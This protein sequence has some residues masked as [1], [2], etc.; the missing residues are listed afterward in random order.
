MK[1]NQIQDVKNNRRLILSLFRSN[2]A[3]NK[4]CSE[5]EPKSIDDTE[6]DLLRSNDNFKAGLPNRTKLNFGLYLLLTF[7][8]KKLLQSVED[9]KNKGINRLSFSFSDVVTNLPQLESTPSIGH[10]CF[11]N[12]LTIVVQELKGLSIDFEIDGDE[13]F[14]T[15]VE[16]DRYSCC[17]FIKEEPVREILQRKQQELNGFVRNKGLSSSVGADNYISMER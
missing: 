14:A 4:M 17:N 1:I 3:Y 8:D 6:L 5:L 16:G 12:G 9:C 13:L 11:K 15:K 10:G 2:S 7:D